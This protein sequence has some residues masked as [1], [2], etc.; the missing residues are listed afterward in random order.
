M[1]HFSYEIINNTVRL[2]LDGECIHEC[3]SKDVG[4]HERRWM[5]YSLYELGVITTIRKDS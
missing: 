3:R 1:L 4:E 2:F 5:L